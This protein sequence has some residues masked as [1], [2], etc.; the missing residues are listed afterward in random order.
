MGRYVLIVGADNVVE[1]RN[2]T[3][4]IKEGQ[5]VV[6]T[7]GAKGDDQAVKADDWVIIDGIQRARTGAKVDPQQ[8]TLTASAG[9]ITSVKSGAT[10][11]PQPESLPADGREAVDQ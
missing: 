4:G 3:V 9:K 6:V 2:V 7:Q 1:R 10:E 8:T 11:P 5:M